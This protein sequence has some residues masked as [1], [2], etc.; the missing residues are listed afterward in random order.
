MHAIRL[1]AP[2]RGSS[3]R[4]RGRADREL[5]GAAPATL[6]PVVRALAFAAV[7]IACPATLAIAQDRPVA[8]ALALAGSDA[9]LERAT[10]AEHV[11]S[12]LGR[13][14]VAAELGIV[15]QPGPDT[16]SFS[17][18]RAGR[19]VATRRFDALPRE[20]NDRRAVLAL[21]IALALDA[22]VLESLGLASA[23]ERAAPP[24]VRR[25]PAGERPAL[26]LE[27]EASLLV[28]VLP[29]V[30][31][32]GAASVA[33][34]LG[35]GIRLRAGAIG[36]QRV[37]AAIG[38]GAADVMLLAGRFDGCFGR[39]AAPGLLLGGCVGVLAGA[40]LAQ[41]RGFVPSRSPDV[42]WV[43]AAP[44][45]ELRWRPWDALALTL[46]V[47][48]SF[49]IVRPKLDVD[50]GAGTVIASRSAPAAGL[51]VAVGAAMVIE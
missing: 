27:A 35:E 36:T 38:H 10:L 11:R 15:V 48:G 17:V 34:L 51:A 31:L 46:A 13:T 40:V 21:A 7:C 37:G 19:V 45:A 23:P 14:E 2:R 42:P 20:C 12:W 5:V 32:A 30:A 22:A 41:G 24:S 3:P 9:C 6:R 29:E 39:V 1:G 4:P 44:R 8:E 49:A 16:A 50:D 28:E 26:S 33:W 47:D 18:T 43:A 25:A